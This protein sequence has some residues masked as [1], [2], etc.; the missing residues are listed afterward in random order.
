MACGRACA[1][2]RRWRWS[3]GGRRELRTIL[4]KIITDL[5]VAVALG[6]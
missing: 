4:G 3:G 2:A 6:G 1:G 5:A